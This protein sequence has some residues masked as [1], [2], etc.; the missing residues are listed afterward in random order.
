MLYWAGIITLTRL[1]SLTVGF[2][3]YGSV[4]FL[5]TYANKATGAALF[6]FPVWFHIFGTTATALIL[7]GVASLSAVEELAIT[8]SSKKLNANIK[9]FAAER[10][11]DDG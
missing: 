11:G 8:I 6:L 4:S 7:C 2:I 3:K 9:Y 10:R 5:H 1:S